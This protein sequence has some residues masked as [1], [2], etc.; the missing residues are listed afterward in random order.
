MK[1]KLRPTRSLQDRFIMEIILVVKFYIHKLVI[2]FEYAFSC[3]FGR[4]AFSKD[5]ITSINTTIIITIAIINIDDSVVGLQAGF[6]KNQ[7]RMAN[8]SLPSPYYNRYI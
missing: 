8:I 7:K 3:M 4:G 6:S 1:K 2:M 5:N